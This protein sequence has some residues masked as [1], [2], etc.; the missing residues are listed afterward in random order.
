MVGCILPEK[1]EFELRTA[2]SGLEFQSHRELV[3]FPSIGAGSA[4]NHYAA[5]NLKAGTF[6][7]KYQLGGD[8][9]LDIFSLNIDSL[10]VATEPVVN[11]HNQ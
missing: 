2:V 1:G 9:P 7:G 4:D 10:P 3:H 8:C 5:V 6:V 11:V